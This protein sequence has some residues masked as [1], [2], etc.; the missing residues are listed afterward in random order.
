[1]ILGLRELSIP[2]STKLRSRLRLCAP[3]FA[4][5][6][7][8]AFIR[9][10]LEV[11]FLYS[12]L[13]SVMTYAKTKDQTIE[14][15][16]GLA[17]VLVVAGYIIQAEVARGVES[18]FL[19]G[20]KSFYYFLKPVRMPLFTVISAYLYASSPATQET[21]RKLVTGKARRILIPFV[22]VSAIQYVFFSV[23][24]VEELA[25]SR[26]WYIYLQ[27]FHQFWFLLAIFW[28]FVIVG[29][30]DSKKA[31]DTKE[32]WL[33]WLALSFATHILFEPPRLLSIQGVN[34]LFPFFLMGYGFRRY[35][36]ELFAP[37]MI[38]FYGV[39]L[40]LSYGLYF[41]L[42]YLPSLHPVY[43]GI[44]LLCSF[45]IV[46]LIF[47]FRQNVPILSK[48]GYYA[49]GI[50]I[51]NKIFSATADMIV[52]ELHVNNGFLSFTTSFMFG[53]FLSI[54]LQIVLER[55]A[56]TK[57]YILGMKVA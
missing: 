36:K 29:F 21:V 27:P 49:F 15:L 16:R 46:P 19:S 14:T 1:M 31:L 30:L 17:I 7:F 39:L 42:R 3:S 35:A 33:G 12:W 22:F 55:F 37:R 40:L 10:T 13:I 24:H 57:K 44:T 23:F 45:S 41:V 20:L 50:H 2:R 9:Y 8:L 47:H 32:K 18:T 11:F 5:A 25:L 34:Y 53:I 43:K 48:I 56:F 52:K 28:I 54:I 6:C 38:I 26:I 4:R 51:F